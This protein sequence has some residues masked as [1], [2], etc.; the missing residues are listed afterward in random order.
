MKD[1]QDKAVEDQPKDNVGD[2]K[3]IEVSDSVSD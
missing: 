3:K 2:P 1:V